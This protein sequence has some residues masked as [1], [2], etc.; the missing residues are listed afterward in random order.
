M[1]EY[2][3][4]PIVFLGDN[5]RFYNG[6]LPANITKDFRAIM[7]SA[8]TPE[9]A[10]EAQPEARDE[11]PKVSSATEPAS[12]LQPDLPESP[13]PEILSRSPSD[14]LTNSASVAKASSLDLSQTLI[15]ND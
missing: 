5:N 7:V 12:D 8:D 6:Q 14:E 13:S 15:G 1:A 10:V 11:D 9:P 3:V 2:E 4:V